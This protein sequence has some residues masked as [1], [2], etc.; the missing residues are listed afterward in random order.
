[1]PDL[2]KIACI[3][4]SARR[5]GAH[6]AKYLHQNGYDIIIHHH[7]SHDEA[8][9]LEKLLNKQRPSSARAISYD[10]TNLDT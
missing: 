3:T 2:R 1:M 10:L 4:G 8:Q 9:A 6:I 7:T 5:I